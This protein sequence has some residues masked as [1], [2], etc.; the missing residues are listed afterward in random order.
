MMWEEVAV[1][2]FKGI[3]RNLLGTMR[4]ARVPNKIRT[5]DLPNTEQE[6]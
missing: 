3:S 6:L 4:R 1:A 2:Y 5:L